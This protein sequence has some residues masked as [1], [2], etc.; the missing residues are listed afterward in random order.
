MRFRPIDLPRSAPPVGLA[1]TVLERA[2]FSG[3]V[4]VPVEPGS[5][6]LTES[7]DRLV[8]EGGDPIVT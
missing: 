5:Q 6:I 1:R 8:T 2:Q 3:R 7:G 4:A